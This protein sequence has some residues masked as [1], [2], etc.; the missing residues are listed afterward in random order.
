[1]LTLAQDIS[2]TH[3]FANM[4][5]EVDE[6]RRDIKLCELIQDAQ[7]K[8]ENAPR[9][10]LHHDYVLVKP[11]TVT[12]GADKPYSVFS[13]FHRNWSSK[14][15]ADLEE[16]SREYS[17]PDAN[18]DSARTDK[19]LA[20][21]F[22][23]RIPEAIEGFELPSDE[24]RETVHALFPPGTDAAEEVRRFAPPSSSGECNTLTF[25]CGLPRFSAASLPQ[26]PRQA[27]LQSRLWTERPL[28]MQKNRG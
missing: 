4:E 23:S 9:P 21:L 17:G 14:L 2:A 18:K 11:G 1:M 24:Y 27:S 6:L 12:T 10:S 25:M 16:A 26:K 13:P 19:K 20:E 3:I 15:Q 5:Y 22:A 8:G 7:N 28:T